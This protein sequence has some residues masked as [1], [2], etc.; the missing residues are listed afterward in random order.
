MIVLQFDGMS[1]S[2]AVRFY[3]TLT[4]LNEPN[5]R[6]FPQQMKALRRRVSAQPAAASGNAKAL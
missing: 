5:W 3:R 1:K 4:P 6:M 2:F